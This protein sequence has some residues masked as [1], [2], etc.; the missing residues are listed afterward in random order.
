MAGA[1]P[2]KRRE[3]HWKG[4]IQRFTQRRGGGVGGRGVTGE[5]IKRWGI[6]IVPKIPAPIFKATQFC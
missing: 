4:L 6:E 5:R 3:I 2:T 1:N